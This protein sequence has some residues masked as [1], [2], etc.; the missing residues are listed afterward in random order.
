MALYP[1]V[2][3]TLIQ[4]LIT[5]FT[6]KQGTFLKFIWKHE[7]PQIAKAILRKK[8]NVRGFKS[9]DFKLC[10]SLL[11]KNIGKTIQDIPIGHSSLIR[12]PK[13]QKIM[14]RTGKWNYSKLKILHSIEN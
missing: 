11:E 14:A 12:N 4:I 10:F 6:E 7:K 9:P 2:K 13:T 5:F 1:K 8:S 3:A